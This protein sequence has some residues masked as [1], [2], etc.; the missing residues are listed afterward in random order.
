M[1]SVVT[2][3]PS[4][5]S[6]FEVGFVRLIQSP[7]AADNQIAHS[8]KSLSYDLSNLLRNQS[9][10]AVVSIVL[11]LLPLSVWYTDTAYISTNTL[12]YNPVD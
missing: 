11:R 6:F 8:K 12:N 10:E 1:V 9:C 2:G 5:K 4:L 7:A 3:I